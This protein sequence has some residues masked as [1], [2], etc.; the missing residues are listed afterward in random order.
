MAGT[1]PYMA[2]EIYAGKPYDKGI[3]YWSFGCNIY[4]MLVGKSPFYVDS[5]RAE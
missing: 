5:S 2:P 4:E 3:D 1:W